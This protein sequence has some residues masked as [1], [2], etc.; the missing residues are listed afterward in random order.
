MS[1]LKK[2]RVVST[3]VRPVSSVN[4]RGIT[5]VL[6]LLAAASVAAPAMA[7]LPAAV[8]PAG[9]AAAGD[10]TLL[11]RQYWKSGVAVLVLLVGTWAFIEV[12]GGGIAKFNEWRRGKVELSELKWFFFIG[13]VMLVLVIYLLTTAN[14]IL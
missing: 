7:D 2:K 9:G 14:G 6:L 12:G 3:D 8:Q 10:Y 11:L 4:R 5:A 1:Y 13:V